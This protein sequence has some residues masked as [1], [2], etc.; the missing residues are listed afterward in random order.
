MEGG[1]MGIKGR[2]IACPECGLIRWVRMERLVAAEEAGAEPPLCE[3]CEPHLRPGRIPRKAPPGPRGS[4]GIGRVV[5]ILGTGK[6]FLSCVSC[7]VERWVEKRF[8]TK[9]CRRCK[10]KRGPTAEAL[11][12][13][14]CGQARSIAMAR[15]GKP[16]HQCR[17]R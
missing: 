1:M 10:P 4:L 15:A 5:S 2:R 12:C 11:L 16:C 3:N 14:A 17:M 7:K 8:A 13:P 6:Q 9:P